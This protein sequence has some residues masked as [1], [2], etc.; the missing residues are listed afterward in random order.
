MESNWDLKIGYCT[1]VIRSGEWSGNDLASTFN[2]RGIGYAK[3][4]EY[5]RAVKDYDQ[6]I[7]INP[8]SESYFYNRAIAYNQ[9]GQNE[10]AIADYDEALRLMPGSF[11]ILYNRA[12]LHQ[13]LG[14]DQQ[15]IDDFGAFLA[16]GLDNS[17]GFVGDALYNRA[18]LHQRVGNNVQAVR[19]YS[20]FLAFKK[21]HAGAYGGRAWNLYLLGRNEQALEDVKQSLDLDK[22]DLNVLDTGAHVLVAMGQLQDGLGTFG[23]IM[24]RGGAAWVRHYQKALATHGYYSGEIDGERGGKTDAAMVACVS[25]RCRLI[26]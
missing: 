6:A 20:A 22:D 26:Q 17:D 10:R 3:L 16:L 13:I 15:A 8:D 7:E 19:D 25:A 21:F 11:A 1:S 23:E 5:E 4:G 24:E 12:E 9:L 18:K 2:N 14:N